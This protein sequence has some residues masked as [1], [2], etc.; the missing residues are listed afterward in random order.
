M[1]QKYKFTATEFAQMCGITTSALRKRRLSGKLEGQYVL[2]NNIYLYASAGPNKD[3]GTH[4]NRTKF[5]SKKRRRNVPRHQTKYLRSHM[6]LAND[7]KQLMRIKKVMREEQIEEITP[8]LVDL[9]KKKHQ[10]KLL[11]KMKE[12]FLQND[13]QMVKLRNPIQNI[14]GMK[15]PYTNMAYPTSSSQSWSYEDKRSDERNSDRSWSDDIPTEK[16]YY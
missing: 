14:G 1:D 7:M 2:E 13:K 12:P 10:E 16:K 8:E 6:Q 9:A 4:T 15:Y 5:T 3:A 11:A